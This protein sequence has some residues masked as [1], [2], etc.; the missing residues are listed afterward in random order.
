VGGSNV[1]T[2]IEGLLTARPKGDGCWEVRGDQQLGHI[3]FTVMVPVIE[4]LILP[5]GKAPDK[6]QVIFHGDRE[7]L[8]GKLRA[9]LV[10]QLVAGGASCADLQVAIGEN[11][12]NAAVSYRQLQNFTNASGAKLTYTQGGFMLRPDGHGLWRG[13]LGDVPLTVWTG[14]VTRAAARL[15]TNSSKNQP[16]K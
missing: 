14:D 11:L 12:D 4:R 6:V 16:E 13:Q 10:R 9:E 15:N 5:V 8:A 1:W 2:N 3:R 7:A